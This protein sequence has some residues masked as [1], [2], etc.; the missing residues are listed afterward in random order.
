M[1]LHQLPGG[2]YTVMSRSLF[3]SF[4]MLGDPLFYPD[5]LMLRKSCHVTSYA[6]G[7]NRCTVC[8][9]SLCTFGHSRAR[10]GGFVRHDATDTPMLYV[11][12]VDVAWHTNSV[13]VAELT[14]DWPKEFQLLRLS[15]L[16]CIRRSK[17]FA[18]YGRTIEVLQLMAAARRIAGSPDTGPLFAL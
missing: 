7:R 3:E 9:Y 16:V 17:P 15:V 14:T 18:R 4:A 8:I 11:L 1:S 5:P 13:S 2:A 10:L 12:R 6:G